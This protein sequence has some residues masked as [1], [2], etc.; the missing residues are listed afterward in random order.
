MSAR[1]YGRIVLAA[2]TNA[3]WVEAG[4]GAYNVSKAGVVALVRT[5]AIELAPHSVTV[6]AVGPGL[7][8]TRMSEPLWSDPA[9]LERYLTHIPAGRLGMPADV[10]SAAVFLASEEASWITGHLLVVDGGQTAG[11]ALP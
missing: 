7:I 10:A 4:M 5:A 11:M 6:N 3:Y 8:R 1:G 2:S 9:R